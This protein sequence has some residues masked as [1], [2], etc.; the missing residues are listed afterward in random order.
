MPELPE[1]EVV[2]RGLESHVVGRTI[3]AEDQTLTIIGIAPSSFE[4][5]VLETATGYRNVWQPKAIEP[6]EPNVRGSGYWAVV[7][8]LK[9]GVTIETS[10]AE[11]Q[12]ISSHLV[13]L[14]TH[15]MEVGAITMMMYCFRE[16]ELLLN[17]N[18]MLAGFRLFPSY[19]R[20]GGLREDLPHGF[21]DAVNAFLDRFP[22]KMDE[23]EGMLTKKAA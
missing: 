5:R 7:G 8:R 11:L 18:E 10:R 20:I 12:R 23:Y 16:R 4:P 2:R 6:Y 15:G 13:W 22:A 3:R 19:I 1:V 14:G 9:P 21:H 17:I